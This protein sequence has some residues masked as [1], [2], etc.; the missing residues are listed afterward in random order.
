MNELDILL[1]QKS[2]EVPLSKRGL[3]IIGGRF[4][5]SKDRYRNLKLVAA[6]NRF[7]K[8]IIREFRIR[9]LTDWFNKILGYDK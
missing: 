8:V 9:E 1:I 4:V 2:R 7:V 5:M 6:W 3:I